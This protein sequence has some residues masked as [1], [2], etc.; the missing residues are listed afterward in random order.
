VNY[1]LAGGLLDARERVKRARKT[2]REVNTWGDRVSTPIE[3]DPA[4][5]SFSAVG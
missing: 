3:R 5:R 2:V 1:G 4:A